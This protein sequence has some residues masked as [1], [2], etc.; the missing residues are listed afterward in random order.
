AVFALT[1][2]VLIGAASYLSMCKR[3]FVT[4][5][6]TFVTNARLSSFQATLYILAGTIVIYGALITCATGVGDAR[7]RVP[8]DSLI[9]F[10]CVLGTDLWTR[11]I[12]L[13]NVTFYVREH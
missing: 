6:R 13:G 4:R 11:L 10:M 3:Q 7:Y 9:I 12:R 1:L 5:N 2:I 8:S